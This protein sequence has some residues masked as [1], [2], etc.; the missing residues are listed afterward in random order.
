VSGVAPLKV[1]LG[2]AV[3]TEFHVLKFGLVGD[4]IIGIIGSVLGGFVFSALGISAGGLIGAIIVATVGAILLLFN[5]S[6]IVWDN[7]FLYG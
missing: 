5:C 1:K 4:I 6:Y 2:M 7:L 3:A